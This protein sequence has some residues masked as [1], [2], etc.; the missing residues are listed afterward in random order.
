MMHWIDPDCL[1]ETAGVVD[2]FL[3][4]PA[5]EADGLVL[6]DGTEVHFPPH[7]GVAVIGVV[8]PGSTVYVRG[9]RPRGVAMIAAVTVSPAE[10]TRIVDGGP[11][12]RDE[13]HKMARKRAHASRTAMEVAG[14]LRQVLHGPK[15]EARG[16]LLEDGRVGRFPPH[17]AE[18]LMSLLVPGTQLLL[19]GDGLT[20]AHGT[21][22][23]IREIG[24]SANDLRRIDAKSARDKHDKLRKHDRLNSE[25]DTRAA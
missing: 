20:T 5:G 18:D 22:V 11:P 21:V 19:R 2:C 10:G 16:L 9:V 25:P 3:L 1:P 15:G 17:A 7:M 6:T 12:E 4:N 13:P 24:T 14:V 23:A 8:K